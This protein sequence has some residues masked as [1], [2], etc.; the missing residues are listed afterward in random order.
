MVAF[1]S[2]SVDPLFLTETVHSTTPIHFWSKS[3][4]STTI[5]FQQ[6]EIEIELILDVI[7]FI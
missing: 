6:L 3:A 1:T 5:P 7:E 2:I 4:Q